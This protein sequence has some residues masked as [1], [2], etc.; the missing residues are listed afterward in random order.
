MTLLWIDSAP[1]AWEHQARPAVWSPRR[2]WLWFDML[3]VSLQHSSS[4]SQSAGQPAPTHRLECQPS[5]FYW[6]L[7]LAVLATGLRWTADGAFCPTAP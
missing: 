2:D 4:K 1:C 5:V 3:H 7:G 6:E